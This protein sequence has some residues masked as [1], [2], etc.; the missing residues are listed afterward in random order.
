M[1][2]LGLDDRDHAGGV[3]SYAPRRHRHHDDGTTIRPVLERLS[4]G[5][6]R[7]PGPRLV[8]RAVVHHLPPADIGATATNSMSMAKRLAITVGALATTA[9]V[10]AG[11]FEILPRGETQA[12]VVNAA[13]PATVSKAD[14]AAPLPK[15]V[16]TTTIRKD[17]DAAAAPTGAGQ[18]R[19]L[20][21][22][23]ETVGPVNASGTAAMASA[24]PSLPGDAAAMPLQ[25]WTM[26]PL[27]T[28][29][30]WPDA[31]QAAV[32]G[33]ATPSDVPSQPEAAAPSR[34]PAAAQHARH[35]VSR[36][37]T[38]H[39]QRRRAG[40]RTAQAADQATENE[41]QSTQPIKKLPLQAAL[42]RIFGSSANNP[43][44]V[45]PPP[46]PQQ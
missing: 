11:V 5:E 23:K 31:T 30:S 41:Q 1:S 17:I 32:G 2:A 33:P 22:A 14:L 8:R 42:D 43:S 9:V 6:G 27:D 16:H 46:Q 10:G 40:S 28:S 21:P 37:R 13:P 7:E 20:P 44:S 15:P 34:P 26:V 24:D 3:L 4:R 35:V 25:L 29:A 38:T 19:H 39:H 12:A 45:P 36:Q 18:A